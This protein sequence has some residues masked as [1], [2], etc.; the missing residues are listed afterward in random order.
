MIQNKVS[1]IFAELRRSQFK[2]ID[3]GRRSKKYKSTQLAR[4]TA[5]A[6][7][8]ANGAQKLGPLQRIDIERFAG[9]LLESPL[10]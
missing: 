7:A 8:I 10:Q 4:P 3:G 2:V 5:A 6:N 9:T 1:R